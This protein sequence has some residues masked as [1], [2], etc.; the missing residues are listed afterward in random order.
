M[1]EEEADFLLERAPAGLGLSP[2][3][4][5]RD[6]DV[7][8]RRYSCPRTGAFGRREGE[9]VG[10]MVLV[11]ETPVQLADELVIAEDDRELRVALVQ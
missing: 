5:D 2:R 7:P 10:R 1:G 3:G 8:E 4:L 6:H 9:D 11:R